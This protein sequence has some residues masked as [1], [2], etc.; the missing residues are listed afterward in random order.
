MVNP[1][2][3]D[4]VENKLIRVSERL[5]RATDELQYILDNLKIQLEDYDRRLNPSPPPPEYNQNDEG[6]EEPL[7]D[8]PV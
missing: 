4:S 1:D 7:A 6:T 3:D 5:E 2:Y 8:E